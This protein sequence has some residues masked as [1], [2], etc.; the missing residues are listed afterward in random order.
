MP[1]K[2]VRQFSAIFLTLTVHC[3]VFYSEAFAE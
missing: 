3:G 1:R 2:Q